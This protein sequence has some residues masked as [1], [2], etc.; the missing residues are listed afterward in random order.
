MIKSKYVGAS[1]GGIATKISNYARRRM[2]ATLMRLAQ[3]TEETTV[4]DVGVT[5]DRRLDSNFF[6][7]LYPYPHKITAVGLEDASFLEVEYPGLKFVQTDGLR[8]P[9][10]DKSF[11]LAVSFAVLEHVGDRAQQRTFIHELCRVSRACCITTPNRWFPIEFHT[12]LPLIHWLPPNFFR[13]ILNHTGKNFWAKEEN[14]NLLG[15]K[16]LLSLFS[17]DRITCYHHKLLGL[18]SNLFVYKN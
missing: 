1:I 5:C 16:E 8:L 18:V 2:F 3:P 14:L 7:K 12:V 13:W 15:Q 6:E 11:D 9:F 4:L 10:P 17:S